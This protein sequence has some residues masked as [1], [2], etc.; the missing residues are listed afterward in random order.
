MKKIHRK[1]AQ[2]QAANLI[3]IIKQIRSL[4]HSRT[5]WDGDILTYSRVERRLIYENNGPQYKPTNIYNHIKGRNNT[6]LATLMREAY[7]KW[8][9]IGDLLLKKYS[10]LQNQK[11]VGERFDYIDVEVVRRLFDEFLLEYDKEVH[12]LV[13]NVSVDKNYPRKYA[14]PSDRDDFRDFVMFLRLLKPKF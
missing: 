8:H 12:E 13:T 2:S 1:I 4:K 14:R 6:Q 5:M 10:Y 11:S 7:K 3:K 9:A